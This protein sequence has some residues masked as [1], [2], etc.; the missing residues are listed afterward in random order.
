MSFEAVIQIQQRERLQVAVVKINR[1]NRFRYALFQAKLYIYQSAE[2]IIW[3]L[4][5][6][7]NHQVFRQCVLKIVYLLLKRI[8][9]AP[10]GQ[11]YSGLHWG[12]RHIASKTKNEA[13]IFLASFNVKNDSGC[14]LV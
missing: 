2:N 1:N 4:R 12:Y 6:E 9:F 5:E 10:G 13:T 3:Q 7:K 14:L 11:K 8:L